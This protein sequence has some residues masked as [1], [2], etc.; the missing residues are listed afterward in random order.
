ML[1][2][3]TPQ[4]RSAVLAGLHVVH[5]FVT[6]NEERALVDSFGLPSPIHGWPERSRVTRYGAGVPATGY[7]S[8]TVIREIPEL[9]ADLAASVA[10]WGP[11]LSLGYDA[12]TVNE[13]HPGQELAFH[14]DRSPLGDPVSILGLASDACMLFRRDADGVPVT[15]PMPRRT[16]VQLTGDSL[17]EWQHAILPVTALRYSIV[18]RRGRA[19]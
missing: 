7:V 6:P 5:E 16:L 8:G 3:D 12:I 10:M 4:H 17:S 15:V 1:A 11:A 14:R 19:T 9:L 18:F 13:Y 2:V